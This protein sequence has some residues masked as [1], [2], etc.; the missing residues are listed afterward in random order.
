L[1]VLIVEDSELFVD[2]VR[3]HLAEQ[4]ELDVVGAAS[5]TADARRLNH[6]LHPDIILLDVWLSD[7]SSLHLLPDLLHDNA[8]VRVIVMTGDASDPLRQ[9]CL[10][11]GAYG[12]FDKSE[13][14][15]ALLRLM[16]SAARAQ[17]G[18]PQQ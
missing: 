15:E 1:R 13:R 5:A 12:F 7:G 6:D 8:G 11:R 4:P 3:A 17:T 16:K 14:F 9:R 2:L 10:E 18:I